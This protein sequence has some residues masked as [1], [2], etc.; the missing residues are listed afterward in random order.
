MLCG[1]EGRAEEGREGER[2]KGGNG[3]ERNAGFISYPTSFSFLNG[4][5]NEDEGVTELLAVFPF[6]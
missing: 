3:V 2:N 4:H 5:G 6:I 1:E